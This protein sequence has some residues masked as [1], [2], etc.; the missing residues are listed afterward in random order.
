MAYTEAERARK[1]LQK[2]IRHE[3]TFEEEN[4]S[5]DWTVTLE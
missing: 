3:E 4:D 2:I 1:S 5:E